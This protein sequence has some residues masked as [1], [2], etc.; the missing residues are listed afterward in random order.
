MEVNK[1]H[2]DDVDA[3]I[4]KLRRMVLDTVVVENNVYHD[5]GDFRVSRYLIEYVRCRNDYKV[6]DED[7]DSRRQV[8]FLSSSLTDSRVHKKNDGLCLEVN[9]AN[10]TTAQIDTIMDT[11]SGSIQKQRL[12]ADF[13]FVLLKEMLT[14]S[15]KGSLIVFSFSKLFQTCLHVCLQSA[16]SQPPSQATSRSV[17]PSSP[18]LQV[19]EEDSNFSRRKNW[20]AE[21]SLKLVEAYTAVSLEK[22]GNMPFKLAF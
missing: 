16:T 9:D 19:P 20:T 22:E 13:L 17:S 3:T 2:E 10:F 7:N 21:D 18:S 12:R 4:Q 11:P 1:Y 15:R 8:I 6:D 5:A 14:G